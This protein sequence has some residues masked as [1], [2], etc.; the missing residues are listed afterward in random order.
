M[1]HD[2]TY[3]LRAVVQDRGGRKREIDVDCAAF[4]RMG[5][6]EIKETLFGAGL[7]VEGDGADVAFACLKAANPEAEILIVTKPGWHWIEGWADPVFVCP[8]GDVFG[9]PDGCA[10]ELS[11]N[12]R[13]DPSTARGGTLDGWN[14]A[15][16]VALTVPN[17][18]H[19]SLGV[20][21]GW[22]AVLSS[23]LGLDT[24]G[25]NLSG[26]S[27]RGKTLALKCGV[28]HWSKPQAG[29]AG[30]TSSLLQ[31][32][33]A[34]DNAFESMASRSTGTFFAVDELGNIPGKGVGA[35]IY[36][37][38]GGV[39]KKRQKADTTLRESY[40]WSTFV[41]FSSELALE[42]KVRSEGGRW[43][44]GMPVRIPDVDVSG[45]DWKVPRTTRD[46]IEAIDHN[47]G[48]AGLL[49]VRALIEHGKHRQPEKLLATIKE[50]AD[51]IAEGQTDGATLRA[52]LP[53][54]IVQMAGDLAREFGL[55]PDE[56]DVAAI[57]DWAWEKF[58][59]SADAEAL[60]PVEQAFTSIRAWTSR[61]WGSSIQD[62]FPPAD[63]RTG[64]APKPT[65]K[66]DGWFGPDVVYLPKE[67]LCEAAGGTLTERAIAK[68]LNERG[69]LAEHKRHSSHNL[70]ASYV[71][72]LGKRKAYAL[73]RAEFGRTGVKHDP[74]EES[75]VDKS[76][77][78]IRGAWS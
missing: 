69:F 25:F 44:T 56:T 17:C 64:A 32:A 43:M 35:L 52:A 24:C 63:P 55:I 39:G 11:V 6:A 77:N 16:R 57:V 72:I 27:S 67:L 71:P 76:P 20:F 4:G 18:E 36:M 66:A 53:F 59:G 22:A 7:R 51:E 58:Q 10:L 1:D 12:V 31:T 3:G 28:A 34:T 41:M 9:A 30:K 37:L 33:R 65:Q 50:L 78:V 45:V 74:D 46:Q 2:N 40:T 75:L 42:E 62:L 49:F 15:I 47:F 21:A 73:V 38:A 60:D 48:H 70:Y 68:A 13:M 29:Q 54:A 26:P 23:L 14:E 19:W 61:R 8:S 5:G